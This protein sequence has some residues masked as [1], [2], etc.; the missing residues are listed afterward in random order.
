MDC[1]KLFV[2]LAAFAVIFLAIATYVMFQVQ[3]DNIVVLSGED[4]KL[5]QELREYEFIVYPGEIAEF[6]D[7]YENNLGYFYI[8]NTGNGYNYYGTRGRRLGL[9]RV[10]EMDNL[11]PPLTYNECQ[12]G[13]HRVISCVGN[14]IFIHPPVDEGWER[15]S[16]LP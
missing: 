8:S 15:V 5:Y 16:L 6:Q 12:P 3:S 9:E 7:N 14:V 4:A 2:V 1:K 11:Y 13:N 10:A